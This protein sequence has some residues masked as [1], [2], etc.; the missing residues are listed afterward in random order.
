[1][2]FL[3][4]DELEMAN[5]DMEFTE[6][7]GVYSPLKYVIP[8]SKTVYVKNGQRQDTL[9]EAGDAH[10]RT[11]GADYRRLAHLALNRG[12]YYGYDKVTKKRNWKTLINEDIWKQYAMKNLLPDNNTSEELVE[13]WLKD[14]QFYSPSNGKSFGEY[15]SFNPLGDATLGTAIGQQRGSYGWNLYGAVFYRRN[16][17]ETKRSIVSPPS[18]RKM[19]LKDV[20]AAAKKISDFM[21]EWMDWALI[22][23]LG[24]NE[25]M[26][27][28]PQAGVDQFRISQLERETAEK[29]AEQLERD[30]QI[31]HAPI[32]DVNEIDISYGW[33]GWD[34]F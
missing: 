6:S 7:S 32:A 24:I 22:D 8:A 33:L 17:I 30:G 5:T 15:K 4:A 34:I 11:T 2:K 29:L 3:F 12:K 20:F 23:G 13:K 16:L 1:M 21:D 9:W 25:W 26:G 19:T 27:A 31:K 28:A 18:I 14:P 10:V